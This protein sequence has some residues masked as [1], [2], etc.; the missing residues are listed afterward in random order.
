[1][2]ETHLVRKSR[3]HR[4]NLLLFLDEGGVSLFTASAREAFGAADGGCRFLAGPRVEAWQAGFKARQLRA[5]CIDR[6]F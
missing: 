6:S 3:E 2:S 4:L 1:L 5:R